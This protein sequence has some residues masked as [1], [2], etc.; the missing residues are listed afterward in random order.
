MVVAL[1]LLS[2]GLW[3]E[4]RTTLVDLL[5][6]TYNGIS[7]FMPAYAFGAYWK[8]TTTAGVTAGI[9]VGIVIALSLAGTHNAP[10]GLNPGFIGLAAN[11]IVLVGVSLITQPARALATEPS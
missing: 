8:R 5:L 3:L 11:V 6:L 10:F 7:Q 4:Y 9:V 1:G 2:L